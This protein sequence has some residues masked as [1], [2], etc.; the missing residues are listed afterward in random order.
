MLTAEG[1]EKKREY[2]RSWRARNKE[3]INK[4]AREYREKNKLRNAEHQANYWN[5]KAEATQ[6]E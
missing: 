2:L 3:H 4:Y 5:R 1:R 6:G